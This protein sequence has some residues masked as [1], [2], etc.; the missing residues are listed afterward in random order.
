MKK[1]SILFLLG[2]LILW[3]GCEADLGSDSD[4]AFPGGS[5]LDSTIG[6]EGNSTGNNTPVEGESYNE[7]IENPFIETSEE[8]IS[9]FSIDADG[10]SYSNTR[11]HLNSG[12][13]PQSSIIRTEEFVNYFNYDYPDPQGNHPIGLEGEVSGCPWADDHKLVRIGIKGR[14]I[15]RQ[16]YPAS[17]LVFLVD[18]SGSMN[19]T[20]EIGLLKQ[21]FNLLVNQLRP[22]DRISLV[23]YASNPRVVLP[24]VSGSE[25]ETIRRAIDDLSAGGSTNGEGGILAA[26]DIAE[27]NFIEGGNN[28][29]ILAT[30]GD[31]NVGVSSQDELVDLIE[32]QR[33]KDIFLTVLGVGRGNYQEGKM[34][35][36]ANN[37][38]GNF[39]YLDNLDQCKKV[40][41][42]EYNKFFAVAKDVK[43]QV[44]FNSEV[45]KSY[46]LIGYENRL[47]TTEEFEDDTKDA[48]EIG[49][50]QCIT[51]LYEI[52]PQDDPNQARSAFTI[53]FR[54]KFP[55]ADTS[56]PIS[57]DIYDEGNSFESAS[58][59][60]R[61]ASAVAAFGL[62]LRDSEYK[63]E[64]DYQK[65][66]NWAEGARSYDP[67]GYKAKFNELVNLAASL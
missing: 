21:G 17:N 16:Q 58:D 24:S 62:E 23:T 4:L 6:I 55:T 3:T 27:A 53:D 12:R 31:F 61:F 32:V 19:G 5:S 48:G 47:L 11:R 40:F 9:T 65:I 45:V 64:I 34:E 57:L 42:D 38:N 37:G 22:E 33:E 20:D 1:V 35:Q 29:I 59:D 67:Y 56:I 60:H 41:V 8:E 52:I 10:A 28:R 50:G 15:V 39:E 26:Y 49:A 44:A 51:A 7:I 25:K 13:L 54:Y 63:G 43:V 46:R 36:I 30:D 14:D 18:V 2:A 66:S